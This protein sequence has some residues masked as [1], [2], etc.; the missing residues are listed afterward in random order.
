MPNELAYCEIYKP[1]CHGVLDSANYDIPKI[2][3]SL[4]YQY[5]LT[6]EEFFDCTYNYRSE[7]EDTVE[8]QYW[9]W[10]HRDHRLNYNPLIR[11]STVIRPNCLHIVEKIEY[12]DYTFCVIKTF[13]LK[14]IQRK[15]K[16]WYHNM[17]RH[18]KN[19]R[20]LMHRSIHGRWKHP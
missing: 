7:W 6:T 4:L 15:W 20:N 10:R 11:D 8:T 5:G 13:W 14:I 17:L 9:F 2:Y 19:P 1:R 3:T 16:K 18:R 12:D